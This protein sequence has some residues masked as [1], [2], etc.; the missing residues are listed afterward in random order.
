MLHTRKTWS[1]LMLA[2][3][4]ALFLLA[5]GG[6]ASLIT[7]GNFSSGDTGF[8]TGYTKASDVMPPHTNTIFTEG[9]YAIVTD[10]SSVHP[11]A[12]SYGDLD[13]VN[14]NHQSHGLM[15]AVNGATDSSKN[16]WAQT[17]TVAQNTTYRFGIWSSSWADPGQNPAH[18]KVTFLNGS[19]NGAELS[20]FDFFAPTQVKTWLQTKTSNIP[21]D[22][23]Q[24]WY[25]G[26]VSQVV[27]KIQDLNTAPGD[28]DFALDDISLQYC[29]VRSRTG[30]TG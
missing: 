12:A 8:A 19:L 3:W 1:Q 16:V 17:V 15:M 9:S 28:N 6:A 27:I 7:N 11:N 22:P 2:F 13:W 4:I 10:P 24:D 21:N 23:K 30:V 18:L 29:P 26:A 25:S 14:T 20:S 5:R